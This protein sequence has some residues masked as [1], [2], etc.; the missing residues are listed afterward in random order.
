MSQPLAWLKELVALPGP[1][2]EEE[3]VRGWISAQVAEL[4]FDSRCDAK[5]NLLVDV[6]PP[7]SVGPT[8]LVT[9][10]LDE[11][12]LMVTRV[13]DDGT[14]KVAA[15]GGAYPWKWGEGPVQILAPQG[16]IDAILSFGSIHTN[17]EDSPA[18]HARRNPLTWDRVWLFTG[19]TH[20]QLVELG[21]RPGLRVV[22]GPSRRSVTEFA[23]CVAS[24]FL[25]DRADLVSWLLLLNR[26]REAPA[27]GRLVFAATASEEVGGDGAQYLLTR[28]HC[29]I[30][31]ALEIAPI[32]PEAQ[33]GVDSNPVVWVRDGYAAMEAQDG[34]IIE[35]CASRA[36]IDIHWQYLSRGGS[37]AS[38]AAARGLVARPVT[39]GMP[40]EN[41]HGFEIMHADAPERLAALAHA[42]L[43]A[44]GSVAAPGGVEA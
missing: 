12:A 33:F 37:D 8:I 36:G 26:L 28:L 1:P 21:V 11:I 32:T 41:S 38:C 9:A 20:G 7:G 35:R 5:G 34:A 27:A 17:A 29:D 24:C 3:A 25:D 30:C 6:S 10:H 22:L 42:Y 4:G 39:L 14:L 40:V 44:V 23:G 13:E 16:P 18:E 15:T 2:G 43:L 19:R 31:V